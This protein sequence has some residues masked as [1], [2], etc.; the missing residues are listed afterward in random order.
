MI[1][2]KISAKSSSDWNSALSDISPNDILP[3]YER[4]PHVKKEDPILGAKK[5]NLFNRKFPTTNSFL[6]PGIL[7][8][9]TDCG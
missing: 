6:G 2:L 9:P 8:A 5:T 1:S 7:D 3:L 4:E